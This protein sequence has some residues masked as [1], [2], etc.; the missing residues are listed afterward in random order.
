[1]SKF[2]ILFY[3][4]FFFLKQKVIYY[5]ETIVRIS[6]HRRKQKDYRNE[7]RL[8]AVEGLSP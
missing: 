7:C 4:N 2:L 6:E 3:F 5:H 1:M 8:A